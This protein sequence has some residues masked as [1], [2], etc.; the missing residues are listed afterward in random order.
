MEDAYSGPGA[1]KD[2]IFSQRNTRLGSLTR[3]ILVT[4]QY[5]LGAKRKMA[6]RPYCHMPPIRVHDIK[7]VV[8]D[9]G[10]L[11][12]QGSNASILR[13]MH[14]LRWRRRSSYQN[15]KQTRKLRNIWYMG[16]S[17]F[18]LALAPLTVNHG[19]I[20]FLRISS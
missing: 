5:H 19:D 2:D 14:V 17:L 6:T 11:A 13:L 1:R 16:F 3:Y 9:I 10:I 18:M 4:I 8:V 7:V 12:H 15:Q 20:M